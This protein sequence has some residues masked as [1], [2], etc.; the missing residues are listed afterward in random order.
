MG[1]DMIQVDE[2]AIKQCHSLPVGHGMRRDWWD[3]NK[4]VSLTSCWSWDEWDM[5]DVTAIKQC[6]SHTV[7]H[8]MSHDWWDCNKAVSLTYCWS[9]DETWWNCTAWK[10]KHVVQ[11]LTLY[12]QICL[13]DCLEKCVM[14]LLPV[15]HVM[16]VPW[17]P[18]C[19]VTY[20]LTYTETTYKILISG[21]HLLFMEWND[22][23]RTGANDN[24]YCLLAL[25]WDVYEMHINFVTHSLVPIWSSGS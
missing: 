8:R 24:T 7:G 6:H 9:W 15:F 12:W 21:T 13:W 3:C 20:F 22:Y 19:T 23:A 5:I 17:K 11:T 14:K 25:I 16:R 18:R 1:W 4:A 10:R 2:T